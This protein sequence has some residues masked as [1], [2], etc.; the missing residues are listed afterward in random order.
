MLSLSNSYNKND[1]ADFVDRAKKN[2]DE[3]QV[4]FALELKLDGLSI[5]IFYE[6]GNLVRALTR[7]DGEY[8]EDVTEN[9]KEIS[10][11]PHKIS[12][13]IDLEIRGEVVLPLSSFYK[14]NEERMKN[15]VETFANPRNAASGTLR[16]LDSKIV[17]KRGLDAYFYFFSKC[18]EL[19]LSKTF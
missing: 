12:E 14:L 11:I 13:E 15:N 4:N 5:S 2:I 7:G 3:E 17:A 18:R 16:Q 8:G 1:I 19:W 6:K 10:S 9:I